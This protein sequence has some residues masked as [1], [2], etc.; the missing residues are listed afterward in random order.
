MKNTVSALT[1]RLLAAFP[2]LLAFELA[3]AAD[4]AA[5][6][7]AINTM[8]SESSQTVENT[9]N[10]IHELRNEANNLS[11][12]DAS[13]EDLEAALTKIRL[14]LTVVESSEFERLASTASRYKGQRFN[15]TMDA[16]LL[17]LR[18]GHKEAF[19][20]LLESSQTWV[21]LPSLKAYLNSPAFDAV[22]DEPR[23]KAY[24]KLSDLP[25]RMGKASLLATP[26]KD[27]LSSAEK[28]A[29]L[30]MFWS[31]V[32]RSFVNFHNVP[33]LDWDKVYL[34][35]LDKVMQTRSTREYYQVM[36]QLAP[37]L[38]DGHTNIY[39]PDELQD[40]FYSRPALATALV[41][42]SVLVTKV[43]NQQLA[44]KIQ[45]GDEI[46]S[47]DGQAVHEYANTRVAP[48]ASSS[49]PQD[50]VVRTYSYELLM[51]EKSKSIR[52]G[53]RDATGKERIEIVARGQE[54]N[55]AGE[56]A[57][58][59]KMLPGDIAYLALDHFESDAGVKKLESLMPTIMK[60]KGLILDVRAN[61]GGSSV[62]GA[63]ILSFLSK[64]P[65]PYARSTERQESNVMRTQGDL[66][67]LDTLRAGVAKPYS[68]ERKEVYAGPVVVLAGAKTF[69]AAEDFL[70][71][72]VTMQRGTVI[73]SATAGSTG[74]PMSFKLPGGGSARICVKHDSF[75]DGREF[76]G[77]GILPD[78][79]IVPTVADIRAGRDVVLDKAVAVLGK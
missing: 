47:I 79:E 61:G 62:H 45:R 60:A 23:F 74:M 42:K 51:G 15:L 58:D 75:P 31:E 9:T 40:L 46:I 10:H 29:G 57:F 35:Y 19:F 76:V 16:A 54:R 37:L 11:K 30:S 21:L 7:T 56:P 66:I 64:K 77:K 13:K 12:P 20:N 67:L 38:Q 70:M 18:L 27:N 1:L 2:L 41:G 52:L 49:T 55:V 39:V 72:F 28:V 63:A 17:E 68:K 26:Y 71:S 73:G 22:K 53:L 3:S 4:I 78:M 6:Q 44:Q 69:S 65:V 24:L 50:K 32:K 48:Y 43:L 33:E 36:T 34:E 8:I 14:A 59:F 5:R 25:A